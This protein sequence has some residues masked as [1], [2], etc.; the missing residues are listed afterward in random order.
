MADEKQIT[1]LSES[2]LSQSDDEGLEITWTE[3]EE[4][5]LVR[6]QAPHQHL[7]SGQEPGH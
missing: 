4:K 1:T 2:Q 3:A 7:E 6:R 5:A